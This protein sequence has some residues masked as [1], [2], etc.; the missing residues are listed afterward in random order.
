MLHRHH[1]PLDVLRCFCC[2]WRRLDGCAKSWYSGFNV[3]DQFMKRTIAI[4]R[5]ATPEENDLLRTMA[6]DTATDDRTRRRAQAVVGF[7]DTGSLKQAALSSG[8]GVSTVQKIIRQYNEKG[9]Q[10]LISVLAPR[11]GDFLARYDQGFWAE[12]L[13][14]VF[15]D[16]SARCRAIWRAAE[17][18]AAC[19]DLDNNECL[20]QRPHAVQ[21]GRKLASGPSGAE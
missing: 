15:L 14:R 19:A 20:R 8:I 10:S 16:R 6:S 11:G 5:E 4:T 3:N 17:A 21:G 1:Q 9:W 7:L 13:V 18:H 12:R 2:S